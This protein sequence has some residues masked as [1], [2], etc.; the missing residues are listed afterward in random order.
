MKRPDP[1]DEE[2]KFSEGLIVSSTDL[3]GIITYANRKFCE[4]AGYTKSEL[5]GKN[6]NIVRHPDMPKAAFK[7]LWDTIQAGKEW[8]GV[9]KN[10]RKDGKYYWVFSHI[11]P[12]FNNAGEVTGYTA[13]RRPASENEIRECTPLYREMLEQ[14][15][16]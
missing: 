11:S 2:F 13:A 12:I 4:I 10:L 16:Q 6:H 15:N 9:V 3:K 5:T 8:T 1:L 7:E 14:E